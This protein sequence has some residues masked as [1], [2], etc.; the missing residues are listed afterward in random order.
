MVHGLSAYRA[1]SSASKV[2]I[3]AVLQRSGHAL[4]VAQV[5]ADVGLHVNTAR[6]HLD[7][8]VASGFVER[9]TEPRATRGRPRLVYRAIDRPAPASVHGAVRDRLTGLLV[10]GF[11]AAMDSPV[12][13]AE[14]AGRSWAL[15]HVAEAGGRLPGPAADAAS[16]RSTAA[17]AQLAALERHLGDLGFAPTTDVASLQVHLHRCPF[18]DLARRRTEVVCAVHLGLARGVLAC[19]GGPLVAERL[20]PFVEPHRCVLHLEE[21]R[22]VTAAS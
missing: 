4:P 14:A 17:G 7:Q 19:Q 15:E 5:A 8:L 10:D 3:L 1:L 22:G 2:E 21:R 12:A 6:E 11:G 18:D 20:D 9:A 13:G 16:E